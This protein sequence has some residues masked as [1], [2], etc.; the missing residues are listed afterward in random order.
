[1]SNAIILKGYWA[2]YLYPFGS[3]EASFLG[4]LA[5]KSLQKVLFAKFFFAGPDI[6][7]IGR[8]RLRF[9]DRRQRWF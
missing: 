2:D 6:C 3:M 9:S 4:L 5:D 8:I 7:Q 1:M